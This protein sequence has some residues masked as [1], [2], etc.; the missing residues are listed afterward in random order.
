MLSLAGVMEPGGR[1]Q[2][3]TVGLGNCSRGAGGTGR[4]ALAV[5]PSTVHAGEQ[6]FGQAAGVV[7]EGIAAQGADRVIA[8]VP[9]LASGHSTTVRPRPGGGRAGQ[10]SRGA[11]SGTPRAPA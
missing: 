7:D 1:H 5:P 3:G 2:Q 8:Q 9:L 6:F 10:R 11:L 4:D